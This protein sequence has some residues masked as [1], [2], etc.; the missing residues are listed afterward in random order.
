MK[1]HAIDGTYELFRAYYGAP[2]STSTDGAEVGATRAFM[3]SMV[4]MLREE[5]VTHIGVA[6]DTVIESFRNQMFDGYKTGAGIEPDLWSQFPLVEEAAAALGLVVWRMV[7]FEADDA[8][9]TAA[10]RFADEAQV[11]QIVLCSPDKDLTQCVVSDRVICLDR[12]RGKLVDED[13]VHDKFG[14]SPASIPDYLGLIGDS[15]DGIPGLPRWGA[16]STAAVLSHYHHI[17]EIPD[18]EGQWPFKVRGAS[19]LAKILRE[20]RTDAELY[21]DLATLRRDVP[22]N[23]SLDDMEWRGADR[24]A[25]EAL[26]QRLG[27]RNVVDRIPRWRD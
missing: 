23:E 21:R 13:A 18:D 2:S 15:A 27:E 9:A 3:R 6:F 22:L 16:K 26:C 10:A 8:L 17:A 12:M 25:V 1:V 20:N 14:V 19:S 11:E 24:P 4:A 7:D 5:D